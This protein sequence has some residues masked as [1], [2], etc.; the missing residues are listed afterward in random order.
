M[1]VQHDK[2]ANRTAMMRKLHV[3]RKQ[4]GSGPVNFL[5]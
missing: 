1:N 5:S 3:A 4:L 2:N